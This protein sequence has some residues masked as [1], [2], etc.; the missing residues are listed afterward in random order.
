MHDEVRSNSV[1]AATLLFDVFRLDHH[2]WGAFGVHVA[3]QHGK[4]DPV[5][6]YRPGASGNWGFHKHDE[7]RSYGW[8]AAVLPFVAFRLGRHCRGWYDVL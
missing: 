4:G 8:L 1:L 3:S 2:R 7:V 6:K 5:R